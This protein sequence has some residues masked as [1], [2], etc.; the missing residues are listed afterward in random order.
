[1][2]ADTVDMPS[3][4]SIGVRSELQITDTYRD[5]TLTVNPL[6]AVVERK[7]GSYSY[8]PPINLAEWGVTLRFSKV[9]PG[10]GKITVE[11]KG[12][13]SKPVQEAWVL[14]SAEQKPFIS[15]VWLGTFVL[16]AGFLVSIFR[17]ASR[18]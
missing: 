4:A 6:F 9:D 16:M 8:A 17:H 2:Q 11:F 3:N 13:E 12:L 14:I 10:T 15:I 5:S 7:D 1:M 18:P